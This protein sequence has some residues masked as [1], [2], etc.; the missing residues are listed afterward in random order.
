MGSPAMAQSPPEAH[1]STTARGAPSNVEGQSPKSGAESSRLRFGPFELDLRA[2]ELRKGAV[3]TR[4]QDQPFEILRMMLERPGDV[5]TRDEL[6]QRLW[7]T[8]TFV[9]FEHSLNAAVKRLRAALGDE[10]DNPQFVETVPRRGYR[11]VGRV[12]GEAAETVR[13]PRLAVLP[14]ANLSHDPAQEYFVDGLTEEMI[15]QLGHRCRGRMGVVARW[16]SMV[17]K[18]STQRMREIG[19]T[20]GADYLLEGSVRRED[21]RVRVTARL[22]E[23]ARETHL[24][25]ESYERHLT[26]CLAVQADVAARIAESL[27]LG[28]P[29]EAAGPAGSAVTSVSAY[30]QYLKGRYYWNGY[31]RPDDEG[32]DQAQAYYTEARRID[33]RFAPASAGIARVHIARAVNYRERPRVA[34]ER[35]RA[36]ATQALDLDSRL[37]EA[38][39]AMGDVR[40]MLAW[41]WRGAEGDY[42]AAIALNPSQENS[43]RA[44]GTMLAI[45]GRG[46]EAVRELERA[47]DLDPLCL[48]VSTAAAWVCYL[49]GD[50]ERALHHCRRA[51]DLDPQYLAAHRVS[52]AV[53]LQMGKAHDGLAVVDAAYPDMVRDPVC[54]ASVVHARAAAGDRAGARE[55]LEAC[56]RFGPERYVSPFHLALAYV[57]LEDSEAAFAALERA[58]A[59][60]DPALPFVAVDPRFAALR[61]D[62]RY[63]RLLG[64]MGLT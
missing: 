28:L 26:D 30:Q 60:A 20:L 48:V 33:P 32:L 16:S 12:G 9:D 64:L 14:F 17:F 63:A 52:S 57:G 5:V 55:A 62:T 19:L 56:G 2:R 31:L 44:Y 27:M 45:L 4:L 49:A 11:F 3:C 46:E 1:P 39:L 15:A 47:A 13:M 42:L 6:R 35:A 29:P 50:Y 58:V 51:T 10:A 7:P 22:V 37:A 61:T 21:D 24:W 43:H 38:R 54:A 40:R 18:G 23:A 25:S 8:G 36:E 34:L 59:D 53:Y 41:D